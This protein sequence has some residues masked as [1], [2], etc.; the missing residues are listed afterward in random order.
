MVTLREQFIE[1]LIREFFLSRNSGFVLKGGGAIR[2]LFGGQRLTKDIDLDFI[3][4]KRTADSLHNT[5]N[6]AIT[7]AAHGLPVQNLRVSSPGKNERTP[8]WKIN[9]NDSSGRTFHIEVEVSRD[10]GRAVPGNVIQKPLTPEAAKGI[11]RFW[12]DIYDEPA[13]VT[14]KLAALLGREVPRDVYDLDLLIATSPPPSAEQI[15]WAVERARLT[16]QNAIPTLRT[17][18]DAL[19]WRRYQSELRD[20]LPPHIAERIDEPEWRAM[21]QRVGNYVE[22]LLQNP[23]TPQ[24]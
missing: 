7:T 20:V 11:A 16:A 10:P 24:A 12:V 18:L 17:R 9:F 6:R 5:V 4:P 14:T 21:K 2:T 19:N 3:N 1:R 13:L 15:Q 8:R 22:Q 23:G